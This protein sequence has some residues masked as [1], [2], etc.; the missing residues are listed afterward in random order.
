MAEIINKMAKV[1]EG[2]VVDEERGRVLEL[3]AAGRISVEEADQLLAALA[4]RSRRVEA[5]E[6]AEVR[7]P[8]PTPDAADR[9]PGGRKLSFDQLVQL[10][11]HGIDPEF[12]RRI[13]R[14]FPDLSFDRL[15][16][17]G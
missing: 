10:G 9:R 14:R 3:V 2:G 5:T 7:R 16:E 4:E 8:R 17:F 6:T 1:E 15:I 11:I 12:V 13:R